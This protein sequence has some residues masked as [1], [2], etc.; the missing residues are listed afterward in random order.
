MHLH[1]VIYPLYKLLIN[2]KVKKKKTIPL[3][4]VAFKSCSVND[5][6]TNVKKCKRWNEEYHKIKKKKDTCKNEDD[7]DIDKLNYMIRKERERE[8]NRKKKEMIKGKDDEEEEEEINLKKEECFKYDCYDDVMKASIYMNKKEDIW[9]MFN[10]NNKGYVK[11]VNK[12]INDTYLIDECINYCNKWHM[13]KISYKN[14]A[15]NSVHVIDKLETTA[16]ENNSINDKMN[17]INKN[18]SFYDYYHVKT[19]DKYQKNRN[20]PIIDIYHINNYYDLFENE[21]VLEMLKKNNNYNK[22]FDEEDP[23]LKWDMQNDTY[24]SN[25]DI[26]YFNMYND[27]NYWNYIYTLDLN[28]NVYINDLGR[29]KPIQFLN[30]YQILHV[31][32][33]YIDKVLGT[34]DINMCHIDN[35]NNDNIKYNNNNNNDNIKYNNYNKWDLLNLNNFD[36]VKKNQK[37]AIHLQS[38]GYNLKELEGGEEKKKNSINY[39]E[40]DILLKHIINFKYDKDKEIKKFENYNKKNYNEYFIYHILNRVEF[41]SVSFNIKESIFILCFFYF[42]NF[43]P[44]ELL[45]KFIQNILL[46]IHDL[47]ILQTL[48]LLKIY[49]TFKNNYEDVIHLLL[50]YFYNI[51]GTHLSKCNLKEN[52]KKSKSDYNF[53]IYNNNYDSTC[54]KNIPLKHNNYNVTYDLIFLNI[55]LQNNIFINN[56]LMLF[57]TKYHINFYKNKID[58]ALIPFQCFC[59]LTN[60]EN[61]NLFFKILQSFSCLLNNYT[62]IQTPQQLRLIL[63]SPKQNITPSRFNIEQLNKLISALNSLGVEMWNMHLFKYITRCNN[64]G[65][66]KMHDDNICDIKICDIKICDIKICNNNICNN[67]ICNNNICNNNICNNNICNNNI[68]NN[69]ICNNNICNNN[70]CNNNICNNNIC[71]NNIC[72]NNICNNNICDNNIYDIKTYGDIKKCTTFEPSHPCYHKEEIFKSEDKRNTLYQE[73]MKKKKPFNKHIINANIK[74]LKFL[75]F[76]SI[77]KNI[78]RYF[79]FPF[80]NKYDLY[81]LLKYEKVPE[82]KL[83]SKDGD[84][85]FSCLVHMDCEAVNAYEDVKLFYKKDI[86]DYMSHTTYNIEN[87]KMYYG[88]YYRGDEKDCVINLTK[89][90]IKNIF[91]HNDNKLNTFLYNYKKITIQNIPLKFIIDIIYFINKYGQSISLSFKYDTTI[92]E[93]YDINEYILRTLSFY[94][95]KVYVILNSYNNNS[96]EKKYILSYLYKIITNSYYLNDDIL[97]DISTSPSKLYTDNIHMKCSK[98]YFNSLFYFILNEKKNMLSKTKNIYSSYN[99]ENVINSY[100]QDTNIVNNIYYKLTHSIFKTLLSIYY[101]FFDY[102]KE[103]F[104]ILIFLNNIKNIFFSL[105]VYFYNIAKHL[106]LKH[107]YDM[108][109]QYYLSI[110]YNINHNNINNQMNDNTYIPLE[111]YKLIVSLLQN[112]ISFFYLHKNNIIQHIVVSDDHIIDFLNTISYFNIS[113]YYYKYLSYVL[114]TN[115]IIPNK[116]T[117]NKHDINN[118]LTIIPSYAEETICTYYQQYHDN[119]FSYFFKHLVEIKTNCIDNLN[120][121]NKLKLLK[122]LTK[123][124]VFYKYKNVFHMEDITILLNRIMQYVTTQHIYI[125]KHNYFFIISSYQNLKQNYDIIKHDKIFN[126]TTY[127]HLAHICEQIKIYI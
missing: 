103:C 65:L 6:D 104:D 2:K 50:M 111:T 4:W 25:D 39:F 121:R 105:S 127:E 70:I 51:Q 40:E 23:R 31:L 85:T 89:E 119:I 71:N 20:T 114:E 102:I 93:H 99:N 43:L 41:I 18:N 68:C 8:R 59:F 19:I 83:N 116:K 53:M 1:S 14:V 54:T 55:C 74:V 47:N 35:N 86:Y 62:D 63:K 78:N 77:V 115:D 124:F 117:V 80:Y 30:K 87:D 79:L 84:I 66:P 42:Y 37:D 34:N 13:Q 96:K 125:S 64:M 67:N 38:Q 52:R 11:N 61:E 82:Y 97:N 118:S 33:G 75:F 26:K 122:T 126:H 16:F 100:I 101:N 98:K 69:N 58:F 92:E 94:Y 12:K 15:N 24:Y 60:R 56:S 28:K 81:E 113:L 32:Y 29:N 123:L 27:H 109:L 106:M 91:I 95:M 49:G 57:F 10:L 45:N 44:F 22:L 108:S 17:N 48:I 107:P 21:H 72:N 110:I 90:D 88:I 73:E 120:E 36:F 46:Q 76:F 3:Y 5:V 7:I 112:I 9:N